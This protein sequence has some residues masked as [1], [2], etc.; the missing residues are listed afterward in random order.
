MTG[1]T[2]LSG[3]LGNKI[4]SDWIGTNEYLIKSKFNFQQNNQGNLIVKIFL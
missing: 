4:S 2:V 1:L 3:D